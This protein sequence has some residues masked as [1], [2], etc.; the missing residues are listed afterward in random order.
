MCKL[1]FQV[2][3]GQILCVHGGLSPDIRTLD[4]VINLLFIH[5]D[6]SPCM[7]AHIAKSQALY[8]LRDSL[9]LEIP[10][11]KSNIKKSSYRGAI[12]WNLLPIGSRMLNS[13]NSFSK[14]MNNLNLVKDI[15]FANRYCRR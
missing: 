14:M 9:K 7:S 11:F 1:P 10:N 6:S 3:D 8:N 5:T 12:L 2:I 15:D 13:V 4:R